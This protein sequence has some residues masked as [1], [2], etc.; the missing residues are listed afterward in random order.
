M[1]SSGEVG[2]RK[3]AEDDVV[4]LRAVMQELWKTYDHGETL[5][6]NPSELNELLRG[7]VQTDI[8]SSEVQRFVS[9]MDKDGNNKI[10]EFEFFSFC[11]SGLVMNGPEKEEYRKRSTMHAHLDDFFTAISNKIEALE[12]TKKPK[13]HEKRI[14]RD[15][16]AIDIAADTIVERPRQSLD[17]VEIEKIKFWLNQFDEDQ[18]HVVDRDELEW[19]VSTLK[20]I[21]N[22]LN[23]PSKAEHYDAL[24]KTMDENEDGKLTRR[25][26][27]KWIERGICTARTDSRNKNRN[28]H[29]RSELTTTQSFWLGVIEWLKFCQLPGQSTTEKGAGAAAENRARRSPRRP[30]I[31]T[32]LYEEGKKRNARKEIR[33]KLSEERTPSECTF[34]PSSGRAT[35]FLKRKSLIEH[36]V[37]AMVDAVEKAVEHDGDTKTFLMLLYTESRATRDRAVVEEAARKVV[38]ENIHAKLYREAKII[39]EKKR[40]VHFRENTGMPRGCTFQPEVS[41]GKG[42]PPPKRGSAYYSRLKSSKV[43]I[44]K[45]DRFTLLYIEGEEG[46][47]KQRELIRKKVRDKNES[48]VAKVFSDR[49]SSPRPQ[50]GRVNVRYD[51]TKHLDQIDKLNYLKQQKD[52]TFLPKINASSSRLG[53]EIPSANGDVVKRLYDDSFK[54]KARAAKRAA[55]KP[56]GCTFQ[57]MIT[58]RASNLEEEYSSPKSRFDRLYESGRKSLQKRTERNNNRECPT[59]KPDMS[60]TKLRNKKL[61]A[62]RRKSPSSTNFTPSPPRQ[63]NGSHTP[64]PL[65]GRY[66]TSKYW[67]QSI[68]AKLKTIFHFLDAEG[69]GIVKELMLRKAV[70]FAQPRE[71][72]DEIASHPKLKSMLKPKALCGLRFSTSKKTKSRYV[73]YRDFLAFGQKMAASAKSPPLKRQGRSMSKIEERSQAVFKENELSELEDLQ[74]QHEAAIKM[75]AIA[76]GRNHRKRLEEEKAAVLKIQAIQRGRSQRKQREEEKTAILKIQAVH[77]GR[78]SR[79]QLKEEKDAILKIQAIQRGRQARK[80]LATNAEVEEEDSDEEESEGLGEEEEERGE[81]EG[82]EESEEDGE[83]EESEE[84]EEE[85]EE[86]ESGEYVEAKRNGKGYYETMAAEQQKEN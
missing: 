24:M 18:N 40:K 81:E 35:K 10:S 16:A 32:K 15:S 72:Y 63:K 5:E 3:L 8:P 38:Q 61:L 53:K 4:K 36:S 13:D 9:I 23:L 62:N 20:E 41:K 43:D 73:R 12:D 34:L 49:K 26:F 42:A 47:S 55:P 17:S 33:I 77:R 27:L 76:R 69:T 70:A 71:V 54:R 68:D 58:K 65:Q 1:S 52:C 66:R 48:D 74:R 31:F 44:D 75:Q 82:E 11:E 28:A 60:K 56:H 57:P 67:Q 39:E 86:E 25:E 83:E 51:K 14:V 64:S 46:R 6:L 21:Q 59:F 7:V 45:A 37:W 78:S 80:K 2:V 19:M 29:G 84:E 85:E 50:G 22:S 79:K 30:G